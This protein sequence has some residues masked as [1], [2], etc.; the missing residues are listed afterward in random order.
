MFYNFHLD[1]LELMTV[2]PMDIDSHVHCTN[3]QA[4]EMRSI[5]PG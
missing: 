1:I 4:L 3:D 5:L 2:D